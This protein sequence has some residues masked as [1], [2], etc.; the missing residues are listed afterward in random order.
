VTVS[1][2]NIAES[3]DDGPNNLLLPFSLSL[4]LSL[5]YHVV[6]RNETRSLSLP[7]L[8]SDFLRLSKRRLCIF[9]AFKNRRSA[10]AWTGQRSVTPSAQDRAEIAGKT[11]KNNFLL[12]ESS[13]L[14]GDFKYAATY[15]LGRAIRAIPETR[16]AS[17][18]PSNL[19]TRDETFLVRRSYRIATIIT[20]A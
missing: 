3:I 7:F 5:R 17:I 9:R 11:E 1:E 12:L 13:P 18:N 14:A 16:C 2:I 10:L 20:F 6:T 19:V 15:P 4:S 8:F